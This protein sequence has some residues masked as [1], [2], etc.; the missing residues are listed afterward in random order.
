MKDKKQQISINDFL[1][2]L[3]YAKHLYASSPNSK[4]AKKLYATLTGSYQVVYDNEIV[5]ETKDPD[6][7]VI[8]Y[9]E[10]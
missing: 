2:E 1:Q 4:G 7:A 9:N 8:K 10:L 5:F 6:L 3:R